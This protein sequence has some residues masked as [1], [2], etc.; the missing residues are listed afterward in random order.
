VEDL[1]VSCVRRRER[2]WS[3]AANPKVESFA[4]IDSPVDHGPGEADSPAILVEDG[5]N[6]GVDGNGRGSEI[7]ELNRE[8]FPDWWADADRDVWSLSLQGR[9]KSNQDDQREG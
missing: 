9:G 3:R 5:Q 4:N 7:L 2:E 1:H 6:G 8:A